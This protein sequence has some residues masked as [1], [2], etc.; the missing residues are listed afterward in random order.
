[1]I[2][3]DGGDA[4]HLMLKKHPAAFKAIKGRSSARLSNKTVTLAKYRPDANLAAVS[5]SSVLMS[6]P[7][8]V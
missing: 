4:T 1:M 2:L 5:F 8:K 3:D 6:D 7:S